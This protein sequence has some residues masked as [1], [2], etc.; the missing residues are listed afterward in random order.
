[1]ILLFLTAAVVPTCATCHPVEA[2]SQASTAMKRALTP[3]RDSAILKAN[4]NL[5]YRSG[6]YRWSITREA[7]EPVYSVTDGSRRVSAKLQWAFGVGTM[8]QTYVYEQNGALYESTLSYYTLTKSLDFTPGHLD[9]PR[10]NIDEA[11]GRLIDSAEVRR[12]FNCHANNATEP[13]TTGVQCEHCHAGAATHAASHSKMIR[14][15][16]ATA[17]EISNLCG[18]CHRTWEDIAV[19]G[20]K[21]VQN[22]RFQPY[23]LANSKCYDAADRRISCT[24][25]HDPH[26]ATIRQ[27]TS[28]DAKCLNCHAQGKVC[29]VGRQDCVTCHM[30]KTEI[31]GIHFAFTDH[32]IRVTHAGEPYPQ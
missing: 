6:N 31:P 4:P 21:S 20:P 7:G 14:L 18:A 25:C 11:A 13:V 23:R 5:Q 8:G 22:I 29:R 12:C 32:W 24:A 30:P 1:M 15:S 2:K 10:R 16:Q 9:L 17:E 27:S 26:A 19:N 3:A 28:Y